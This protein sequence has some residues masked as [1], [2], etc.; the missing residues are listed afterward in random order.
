MQD[1]RVVPEERMARAE[2]LDAS[3][4]LTGPDGTDL[5]YRHWGTEKASAIVLAFHDL[6]GHGEWYESLAGDL[7][8]RSLATIA[9]DL[10]GHGLSRWDLGRLPG[11]ALLLGDARFWCDQAR[12]R[13]PEAPL[14]L[15]GTGFG[16]ALAILA[17][18][19]RR[20]LEGVVLLSPTL[21]PSDLTWREK[22]VMVLS[23]VFGRVGGAPTPLGR[24]LPLCGDRLRQEWLGKDPL[25]LTWLPAR[26]LWRAHALSRTARSSLAAVTQP[27]LCVQGGMDRLTDPRGNARLF[28]ERARTRFVLWEEGGHDL[29]L[30]R[31]IGYLA[32][33]LTDWMR[34]RLAQEDPS[35]GL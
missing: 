7:L 4:F 1:A 5:F 25:A 29:A 13:F 18:A 27:V 16:G 31:E 10:R 19:G 21:Q 14:F 2:L 20:D 8:T 28:G 35:A 24:G 22:A 30:E 32:W 34:H 9:P 6:G 23:L 11:R 17:A 3:G 12:A 15:L 26:S 33:I